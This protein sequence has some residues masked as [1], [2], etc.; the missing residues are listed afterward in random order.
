MDMETA[1]AIHDTLLAH[2]DDRGLRAVL[3]DHEGPNFSYGASIPEH[4][5]DAVAEMLAGMHRMILTVLDYP[6]PVLA[7]IN[8]YCLGG[9]LELAAAAHLRFAGP[10]AHLGQPEVRLSVFAPTASCL[11]PEL[12]G[13]ARAEDLLLSGRLVS[14]A[15]ARALGLVTATAPDPQAAA[16]NYFEDHLANLSPVGLRHATRAARLG[17]AGRVRE[18]LKAIEALYLEELMAHDDPVEGLNAFL[19]KRAPRWRD[20]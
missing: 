20:R 17:F 14:G 8:G 15:E 7:A 1:E 13:Q 4:L 11:L 2:R 10:E 12:I 3:L 18:K 9:G 5:P 19:E 16:L 6:L